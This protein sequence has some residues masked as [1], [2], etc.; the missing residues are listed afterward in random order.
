MNW[1]QLF[2]WY[3]KHAWA[4]R[5]DFVIKQFPKRSVVIQLRPDLKS[6]KTAYDRAGQLHLAD[7]K[8][9]GLLVQSRG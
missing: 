2:E 4:R 3:L 1:K 9:A 7:V 5:A 8:P 6:L